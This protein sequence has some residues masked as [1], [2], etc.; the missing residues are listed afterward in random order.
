MH[1]ESVNPNAV[2]FTSVVGL[3]CLTAP[4]VLAVLWRH[5]TGV[6]LKAFFIGM[7]IFAV[8]Q[9]LLRLSWLAPLSNWFSSNYPEWKLGYFLFVALTAAIFEEGGRW[10]AFR[11]LLRKHRDLNSAVMY[12]LGHGGLKSMLFTGM[13]LV[14]LT[15]AY[16]LAIH[17]ILTRE[18][19]LHVIDSQL[20]NMAF[21]LS[22][23]ALL[24]R[25]AALAGQIGLTLI[26]LKMFT[27]DRTCWFG[28]AVLLHFLIDFTVVM[29][30]RYWEINR[31]LTESAVIGFSLA[32]LLC[33]IRANGR[34]S[35]GETA[36]SGVPRG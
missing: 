6:P 11:Y 7:L 4:T 8:F 32:I 33:G 22:T 15:A 19:I 23:Y 34:S 16:E 17:G 14:T 26:V 2:L 24:E 12:G 25:A 5:R 13:G 20:G 30:D 3:V 9:P 36:P 1:I 29:M 18:P 35:E 10:I 27:S 31:A 28:L 21:R